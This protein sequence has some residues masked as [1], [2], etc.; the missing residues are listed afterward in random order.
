MRIKAVRRRDPLDTRA[1]LA[2]DAFPHPLPLGPHR[3]GRLPE[4]HLSPA[5][6]R[7]LE[8]YRGDPQAAPRPGAH[9]IFERGGDPPFGEPLGH[10]PVQPASGCFSALYSRHDREERASHRSR[11][12]SE[13]AGHSNPRPRKGPPQ[14]LH[15][16]KGNPHRHRGLGHARQDGPR[17][18]G[19][20]L[21][22]R[23]V[24]LFPQATGVPSRGSALPGAPLRLRRPGRGR[25]I[26]LKVHR[27]GGTVQGEGLWALAGGGAF[28]GAGGPADQGGPVGHEQGGQADRGRVHDQSP[29]P[30]QPSGGKAEARGCLEDC[31]SS[32]DRT[33]QPL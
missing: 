18:H 29:R 1:A 12:G 23:C 10:R 4:K 7:S 25:L 21:R 19:V 16:P 20:S 26:L 5:Q 31:L 11:R 14:L 2:G 33:R 22:L 8:G 17:D 15:P 32:S 24:R 3:V 6:G 9:P 13:R 27:S 28:R 30:R